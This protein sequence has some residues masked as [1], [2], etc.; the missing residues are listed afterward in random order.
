MRPVVV[1]EHDALAPAGWLGDALRRADLPVQTVRS[2]AGDP[3]PPLADT[4]A[5]VVLGG[6]QSAYDDDPAIAASKAAVRAAAAAGVPVLGVCLGAQIAAAALG[7]TARPGPIGELGYLPLELTPAGRRD[8]V[9]CRLDA[10]VLEWHLDT[11]DLPPGATLLARSARY[12]QAFRLGSVLA[13]QF[14]AEAPPE[15][16]PAWIAETPAEALRAADV[17]P[18]AVLA[19]GAARRAASER[20]AAALFDAWTAE[21]VTAAAS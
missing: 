18:D 1:V 19:E 15:L 13:V 14:H 2:H 16:L 5:L 12:P 8:P 7:G 4:A 6:A 3:L 21:V 20:V 17:E 10:P 11:F 9:L